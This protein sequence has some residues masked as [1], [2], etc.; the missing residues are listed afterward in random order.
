MIKLLLTKGDF[1]EIYQAFRVR[2]H[3]SRIFGRDGIHST[4]ISKSSTGPGGT[5]CMSVRQHLAQRGGRGQYN[6]QLSV[7]RHAVRGVVYHCAT[8]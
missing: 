8:V 4:E 7:R 6:F 3:C 2:W 5:G 1:D